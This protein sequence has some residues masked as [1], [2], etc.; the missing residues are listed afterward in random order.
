MGIQGSLEDETEAE[1]CVCRDLHANHMT[2]SIPAAA[3][4]HLAQLQLL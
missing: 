1:S 2:G 4:G 3:L